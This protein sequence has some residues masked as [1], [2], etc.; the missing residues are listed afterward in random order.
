MKIALA[1]V[2]AMVSQPAFAQTAEPKWQANE[3]DEERYGMHFRTGTTPSG[4][5]Y[6]YASDGSGYVLKPGAELTGEGWSV[7]CEI[8]PITDANKCSLTARNL[9]LYMGSATTVQSVCIMG[10]DFPG[11]RGAIRVDKNAPFATS[12]GGCVSSPALLKQMMTGN[13]AAVRSVKW[14]NDYDVDATVEIGP[15]QEA[16]SL[17]LYLKRNLGNF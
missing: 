6:R 13:K 3:V 5:P 14:P 7:K 1:I 16:L 17:V 8:D 12:E 15:L 2:A 9:F 10:H 11:R 4:S